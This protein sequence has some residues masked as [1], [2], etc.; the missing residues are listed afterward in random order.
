MFQF[1]P[2]GEASRNPAP[3][4]QMMADFAHDFRDGV[5]INLG[6]G[7]VNE[8]TIPREWLGEAMAAVIAHPREHRQAFNYGGPKGSPNLLRALRAY[9]ADN[10]VGGLNES[11]LSRLDLLIGPS[12]ATSI[13]E[14]FAEVLSPGIVIT[15]DPMYYIYCNYLERKGFQVVTVP[16]D[17]DGIDPALLR[18]KLDDLGDALANLSFFYV[19]TVNNPS[20]TLL[21]NARRHE[22]TQLAGEVSARLGRTVPILFDTAYEWLLHDTTV[23]KPESPLLH[24]THGVA[25]EVGT[26]SKVLA[27]ALRVGFLLGPPSELMNALVQHTSDIG[28]SAPLVNQE[29][30]AYLIE[31]RMAA[32]MAQ[33]QEGYREKALAVR[34]AIERNLGPYLEECRGGQAG[35][36]F[37]L[38]LRDVETAPG[39]PFFC[40]LTRTTGDALVDGPAGNPHSRVIYIPGVYCV[41][42][43]GESAGEG[44][45]QLRVSYGFEETP[46]ILAALNIL[47][48]AA[49]WV[50]G[51]RPK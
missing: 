29:I 44:R 2:Y 7:Y 21:S 32:Q 17:A 14:G 31:H 11:L 16:E 26:L 51:H 34:A 3:V 6:V 35:F 28:F 40:Y 4:N 12:G 25:F 37:Y 13:L 22:L 45:R 5:D 46:R 8:R 10:Q 42:P 39:T 49:A 19:V 30:A 18:T 27:P 43:A 15:A 1:S 20:C 23:E 38:T 33:V 36:Y 24:D 48:D 47:R 9:L 50:T 41:H